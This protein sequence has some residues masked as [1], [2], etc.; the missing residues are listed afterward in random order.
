MCNVI[1]GVM[2]SNYTSCAIQCNVSDVMD[3]NVVFVL[4]KVMVIPGAV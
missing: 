4:Y 3:Y 2:Q 1:L